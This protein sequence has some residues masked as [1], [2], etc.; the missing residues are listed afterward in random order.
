MK[1]HSTINTGEPWVFEDDLCLKQNR[2]CPY[3]KL[4]I[5]HARTVCS[6]RTRMKALADPQSTVSKRLL[7]PQSAKSDKK[8]SRWTAEDDEKLWC[9]RDQ[10]IGTLAAH[11]R[12]STGGIMCRLECLR[13]PAHKAHTRLVEHYGKSIG[14]RFVHCMLSN[15][16]MTNY[17]NIDTFRVMDPIYF[18]NQ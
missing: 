11:F 16:M 5:H 9:S 10:S 17:T 3:E 8:G 15:N 18:P 12:R 2:D 14:K 13:D 6:I 1:N 7:N 4:A